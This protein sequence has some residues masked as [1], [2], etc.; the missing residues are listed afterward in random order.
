[1]NQKKPK[2][3]KKRQQITEAVIQVIRFWVC[4]LQ[5]HRKLDECSKLSEVTGGKLSLSS[6]EAAHETPQDI[7]A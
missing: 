3:C 6:A 2:G 5:Q 4:E 7:S 1:M